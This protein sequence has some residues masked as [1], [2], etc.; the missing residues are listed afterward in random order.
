MVSK[1]NGYIQYDNPNFSSAFF[2]KFEKSIVKVGLGHY[3]L[4]NDKVKGALEL[5]VNPSNPIDTTIKVAG[6]YKFDKNT[7]LRE[8]VSFFAL[9]NEVRLGFVLKQTLSSI[10]K[11]T[12]STDISA[13]SFLKEGEWKKNQYGVTLSF[14]D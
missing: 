10:S 7:K 1:A 5:S 2:A 13:N 4:V 14:F 9:N 6:N 11:L 8:R 12:L 3:H